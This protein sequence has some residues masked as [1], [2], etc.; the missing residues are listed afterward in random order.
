MDDDLHL[1]AGDDGRAREVELLVRLASQGDAEAF[2]KLYDIHLDTVYRYIYY[3]VR[4]SSEA[5]DLTSRVFLKAWEAMPRYQL[6]E[7][8]FIHWLIRLARNAVIDRYRTART[9][10]GLD[11]KLH[12]RELD[13]QGE[14]LRGERARELL[15]AVRRLPE[16]Y[17]SVIA[18]RF[19]QD[20]SYQEL[21]GL[22]GKSPGALRVIQH[23]ALA[24]LRQLLDREG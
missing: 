3:K 12:S 14:Y 5:E 4:D 15:E 1:R 9:H 21:A 16:E 22:M 19:M 11:E 13:P 8:P 7:V 10:E 6:R 2:G 20:M 23:R 17:Q 24:A 18:L